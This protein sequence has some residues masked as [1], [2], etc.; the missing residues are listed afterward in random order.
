VGRS[1]AGMA[2]ARAS[3]RPLSVERIREVLA[4]WPPAAGPEN[5][6]PN[7]ALVADYH[8]I[9]AIHQYA[10]AGGVRA[11]RDAIAA[12]LR[13]EPPSD[14]VADALPAG[15]ALGSRRMAAARE[16]RHGAARDALARIEDVAPDEEAAV[17]ACRA[18]IEAA[19]A[20]RR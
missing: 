11:V 16:G 13:S 2:R 18:E 12:R 6:D 8:R 5:G 1:G 17:S 20:R 10:G 7:V 9:I 14:T 19:L 4:A 3:L 15:S